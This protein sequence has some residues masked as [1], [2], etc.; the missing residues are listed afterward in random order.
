MG[1]NEGVIKYFKEKTVLVTGGAGSIGSAIVKYLVDMDVKEVRAL[2]INENDLVNLQ[3][4]LSNPKLKIYLA[5][6]R[7]I[8]SLQDSISDV[9]IVIHAGALK[10]VLP[11]EYFPME[12]VKTNVIGTQNLIELSKKNRVEKFVL[13]STDKAVEPINVMGATKLLAE[14]L[15]LAANLSLN[16][17]GTK[18]SCVRFGNVLYT[19][20]S[21]LDV[22]LRQIRNNNY[23]TVTDPNMTRFIM[24]VKKATELVLK[25]IYHA[26]GGEIFIFK[27]NSVRIIDLAKAFIKVFAPRFGLDPSQIKIKIVGRSPGEKIHEKLLTDSETNCVSESED[28]YIVYSELVYPNCMQMGAKPILKEISPISS[29][30]VPILD[31]TTIENI[32]KEFY[33]FYEGMYIE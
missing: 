4:N 15:T 28:M 24:S 14:K 25:A 17:R 9:D 18:F 32:L 31:I 27:M 2:D 20:G 23:L 26:K 19:K 30:N 11:S 6:I 7:D 16:N 12:Y 8:N 10:H 5:D 21:V 33:E 1:L 29:N 13:I 22:F 3:R